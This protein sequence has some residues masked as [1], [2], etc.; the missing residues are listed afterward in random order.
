MRNGFKIMI[1]TIIGTLLITA[2]A[3]AIPLGTNITTWDRAGGTT[4]DNEV[5]P[6]CVQAQSWDLEGIYQNGAIVTLVGGFDFKRGYEGVRAGDLFIDV[7]GDAIYGQNTG[8]SGNQSDMNIFGY[9]YVLDIDF[10]NLTYSVYAINKASAVLDVYYAQNTIANPWRY[11]DGGTL[12]SGYQNV[13]FANKYWSGLSNADVGGLQGWSGNN[14]HYATAFDLS[15]LNPGTAYT[16]HFTLECGNDN[17]MGKG[18]APAP[19][20]EPATIILLGSGLI[21]LAKLRRKNA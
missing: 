11:S 14:T 8:R 7:N 5:E 3:I 1:L 4:E 2:P 13:S 16:T 17:L 21:G 15:F 10:D 19:V 20:P 6:N 12:V 9:D 18:T